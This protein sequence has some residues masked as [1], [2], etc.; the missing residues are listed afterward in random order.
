MPTRCLRH[1]RLRR[2]RDDPGPRRRRDEGPQHRDAAAPKECDAALGARDVLKAGDVVLEVRDAVLEVRDVVL[3]ARDVVLEVRDAVLEVRDAVLEVRD[4]V[5][6]ARDAVLEVRDAVL[7]AHDADQ[8][9]HVSQEVLSS[10]AVPACPEVPAAPAVLAS[11]VVPAVRAVLISRAAQSSRVGRSWQTDLADQGEDLSPAVPSALQED[12]SSP[13]DK[14]GADPPEGPSWAPPAPAVRMSS[15]GIVSRL[16][17]WPSDSFWGMKAVAGSRRASAADFGSPSA[18]GG[19]HAPG[20]CPDSGRG[21]GT[22]CE[23]AA[24]SGSRRVGRAAADPAQGSRA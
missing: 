12:Q 10:P 14:C 2:V 9:V 7:E 23:E 20:L 17:A 16:Q 8:E 5:L 21:P 19:G 11:L 3:E 15:P 4:A 22:L 1:D 13:E 24:V 18:A 6:E